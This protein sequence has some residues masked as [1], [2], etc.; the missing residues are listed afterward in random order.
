MIA[1]PT[2]TGISA[3]EMSPVSDDTMIRR[4]DE[5]SNA[6]HQK[7]QLPPWILPLT[8]Y[9]VGQLVG[10]VWWAAMMQSDVR[11]LQRQNEQ[12]WQKVEVHDLQL[13]KLDELVRRAVKEAMQD[14][15]YVRIEKKGGQ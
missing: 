1:D 5:I 12:L 7:P 6:I 11:Y 9:L 3:V 13:G 8:I 14:S 10:G 4:L 15:D 2:A